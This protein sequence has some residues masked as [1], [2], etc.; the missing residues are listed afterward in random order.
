MALDADQGSAIKSNTTIKNGAWRMRNAFQSA[1]RFT[2]VNHRTRTRV[3]RGAAAWNGRPSYIVLSSPLPLR[4]LEPMPDLAHR[5]FASLL[6]L[7]LLMVP[8]LAAKHS[9]R[10]TVPLSIDSVNGAKIINPSARPSGAALLRVQILLDRAHF[11]PG[12]ID[13]NYGENT[14]KAVRIYLEAKGLSRHDGIDETLLHDLIDSDGGPVLV[15]YRISEED[16]AGPFAET[17]PQDFRKMARMKRLSYTSPLELLAEK[18][19]MSEALLNRLNPKASFDRPG[20]EIVVANVQHDALSGK[21]TRIEVDAT[22][23]RVLAYAKGGQLVAA[24]PATV[25]S[26][27]RP[28]PRGEMKVTTI[29]E[30]PTYHYDPSL[31]FKGVHADQPLDLPPGPNNPVGVVWIALSAKGYGIHGTPDPGKIS[32]RA[33][34]GC[35]RLTNWDA[36]ELARHVGKGTPVTI[37]GGQAFGYRSDDMASDAERRGARSRHR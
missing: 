26:T 35:I 34:H 23:Q 32:K 4:K 21:I 28:S 19:H 20:T 9:S 12:E 1:N 37:E 31:N 16:T 15:T 7:G 36:L 10:S 14:R 18:F 33:S 29:A 8:A 27:E 30:N 13:D 6:V 24:Y 11:S 25:G 17:I 3:P 5:V 22:G 2:Q